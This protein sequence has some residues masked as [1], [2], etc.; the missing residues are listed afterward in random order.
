MHE[1]CTPHTPCVIGCI[2]EYACCCSDSGRSC[3]LQALD[4]VFV[5]AYQH[6]LTIPYVD[7]LL[8]A[9]RKEFAAVYKPHVY[10]Y[11]HF[12]SAYKRLLQ[13]IEKQAMTSKLRVQGTG[14]GANRT[15]VGVCVSGLNCMWAVEH[16]AWPAISG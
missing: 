16:A 14:M 6:M 8:Q 3:H 10:D 12:D 11:K 2:A 1:V 9:L 15:K 13:R 5:A 4:L 7:G